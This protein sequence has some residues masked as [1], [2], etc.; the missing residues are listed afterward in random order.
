MAY[1]TSNSVQN[2]IQIMQMYAMGDVSATETAIIYG[3]EPLWGAS[4]A[5]FLLDERW[6][7]TTWIGAAL[8][9][10]KMRVAIFLL[11]LVYRL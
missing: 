1:W 4:F 2:W 9:L 5:W 10:C 3:M 8:V 7:T 11:Y 6:D